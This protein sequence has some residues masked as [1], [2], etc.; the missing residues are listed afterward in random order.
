MPTL[1]PNLAV[2][3]RPAAD[4]LVDVRR[5]WIPTLALIAAA[6]VV[7]S[8]AAAAKKPKLLWA[9]VNVCD[10][11]AHPNTI[12]IRASMPGTGKRKDRMYMRFDVQFFRV[13]DDRWHDL[14]GTDGT[15]V[16]VGSG[17]FHRRESGRNVTLK[18]PAAGSSY[19]V[20]GRVTFEW[21][22]SAKVLRRAVR[23]TKGG[24]RG[25][26][27]SDPKGYSAAECRILP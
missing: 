12:G 2:I 24:H 22:R 17:R 25:T 26:T 27:G 9:T 4:Y 16:F 11:K 6:A 3:T 23:Y 19:R 13:S 1:R 18:P 15:F 14:D 8:G 21:R 7:P 5:L 10:T 20:R